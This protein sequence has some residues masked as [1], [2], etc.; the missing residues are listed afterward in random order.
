M[1]TVTIYHAESVRFDNIAALN[2]RL[3]DAPALGPIYAAGAALLPGWQGPFAVDGDGE[4]LIAD[5]VN[6]DRMRYGS[7]TEIGHHWT[8]TAT[9]TLARRLVAGELVLEFTED[10]QPN[11]YIVITPGRYDIRDDY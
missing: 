2:A 7:E 11:E 4:L 1:T 10:G 8:N 6:T 9:K 5:A 3:M